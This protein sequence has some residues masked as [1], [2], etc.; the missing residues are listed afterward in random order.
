MPEGM[1]IEVAHKLSEKEGSEPDGATPRFWH[2]V[3]EIVEVAMLA[4]VAV[5]TAWSG[6]QAAKWDGEQSLRYGQASSLRFEAEAASTLGGQYL[7]ADAGMFNGYLQAHAAGDTNLE[8]QYVRRFTPDYKV[9]FDAWLKTDPFNDPQAPPGPGAMP[10]LKNPQMEQAKSL[11]A[12]AAAVFDEGTRARETAE[13]YVRD[14]VLFASVLF[15]V[16]LAQ[17]AKRHGIRVAIN[18]IA[19]AMLVFTAISVAGLPRA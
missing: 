12:D 1:A 16:A 6:F 2:T 10:E 9:A 19:G 8:D 17:R 7:S 5:L 18:S 4:T 11:N 3:L 13:K 15:L 14:T